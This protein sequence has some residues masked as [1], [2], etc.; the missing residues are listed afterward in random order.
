[1]TEWLAFARIEPFGGPVDDLRAGLAPAVTANVNRSRESPAILPTDFF[2]WAE[3]PAP[4]EPEPE[5]P[6]IIAARIRKEIFRAPT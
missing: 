4:P 6:E 1:M 3:K 5:P 2:P